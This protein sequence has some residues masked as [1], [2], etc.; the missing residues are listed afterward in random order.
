MELLLW[1]VLY[2]SI[3]KVYRLIPMSQEYGNEGVLIPCYYSIFSPLVDPSGNVQMVL[4]LLGKFCISA[5]FC[6]LYAY[7]PELYST[8]VR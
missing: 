7:T 1:A 4:A 5:S 2:F 6:V 8:D 3:L